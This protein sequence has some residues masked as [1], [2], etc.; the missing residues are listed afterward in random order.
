MVSV[1]RSVSVS[2]SGGVLTCGHSTNDDEDD[3]RRILTCK[4]PEDFDHFKPLQTIHVVLLEL[5]VTAG[6]ELAAV[7]LYFLW[8]P[9]LDSCDP[10][11]FLIYAHAVFWLV[12]YIFHNFL[13]LKHHQLRI[14]GYV[15]F[16][17]KIVFSAKVKFYVVSGINTFLLVMLALF[18]QNYGDIKEQCDNRTFLKPMEYLLCIISLEILCLIPFCISY[19]SKVSRFNREKPCPDFRKNDWE[20]YMLRE[21]GR[22]L[23]EI[24]F[25]N[26]N[27]EIHELLEKQADIIRCLRDRN[28]ALCEQIIQLEGLMRWSSVLFIKFDSCTLELYL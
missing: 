23:G 28:D 4:Y 19:I 22:P 3:G 27:E 17:K 6:L 26:P 5:F 16:Y 12:I 9:N 1:A 25:R 24:G 13:R 7:S 2:S 18:C 8:P 21:G 20:P 15:E 11:F 14:R 10:F